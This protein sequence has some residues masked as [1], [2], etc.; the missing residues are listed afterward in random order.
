[1]SDTPESCLAELIQL[2]EEV[3]IVYVVSHYEAQMW[4]HDGLRKVAVGV[5][6]TPEDALHML[7]RELDE[8]FKDLAALRKAEHIRL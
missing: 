8:K 2:H 4:T 3:R 5:G 1:M 7:E 6:A